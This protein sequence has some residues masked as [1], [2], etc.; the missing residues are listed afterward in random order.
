MRKFVL[1]FT[2]LVAAS[3]FANSKCPRFSKAKYNCLT[4]EDDD[5]RKE[6]AHLKIVKKAGK[7]T[8]IFTP[9]SVLNE[10]ILDNK[11]RYSENGFAYRA[12]CKNRKVIVQLKDFD[13]RVIFSGSKKKAS[14]R[15]YLY[16]ERISTAD[17]RRK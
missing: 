16:K 2:L 12:Y 1:I 17:C 11:L 7:K 14:M 4:L 6:K 15:A 3:S 8:L 13:L 5:V 9:E 10:L